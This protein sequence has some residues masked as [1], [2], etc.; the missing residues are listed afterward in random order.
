LINNLLPD[1]Y[2]IDLRRNTISVLKEYDLE[3]KVSLSIHKNDLMFLIN[4]YKSGNF[5]K[6]LNAY[7]KIGHSTSLFLQDIISDYATKQN[8]TFTRFLDFG[9]GYGRVTRFLPSA[10][11]KDIEIYTSEI[12]AEAVAFS[13][14]ELGFKSILHGSQAKSFPTDKQFDL[15]FAGSIFSHLPETLFVEWLAKLTEVL[16]P[17]GIL[18]FS[19]H[20]TT[21]NKTLENSVDFHYTTNSEDAV[22]NMV[23]DHL[24]DDSEYGTTFISDKKV[25]QL[26]ENLSLSFEIKPKAFGNRQDVVIAQRK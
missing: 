9:S 19:T 4:L 13:T 2:N 21:L 15:I 22:L 1:I 5:D 11:G 3:N 20:N 7:F 12:K 14:K 18:M 8:Q 10:L 17:N 23:S 25:S 6:S 24:S 26:M 16:S